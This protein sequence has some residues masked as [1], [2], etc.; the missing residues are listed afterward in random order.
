MTTA[1]VLGA[2]F[3]QRLMPLTADRPKCAV[4]LAGEP[5]AVRILRQLAA[6]G[7]DRAVVVVGHQAER[8]RA[9]IKP[10]IPVEFIENRDYATTNTMYST[11]LAMPQLADGGYLIEGDIACSD[12]AM[13]RLARA[14]GDRSHWAASPW[15]PAHSGSRLHDDGDGRIVKQ[16]IWRQATVGPTERMW[17]S[18]GILK[19]SPAGAATL[20]GALAAE[21][22]AGHRTIYYDDVIGRHL[23]SFDLRI[24][25]LAGD[26]WAEIDD[27][28]DLADAR[29]LFENGD[30]GKSA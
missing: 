23:A 26:S 3:G 25:P 12:E 20:A 27:Q 5:L 2:G 16:E 6:R 21:D 15:T 29:R 4:E 28:A 13:D 8:A 22:G 9:L 14:A 24:L 10:P 7:V 17:K 19:L 30:K 18:A 1:V 11:L